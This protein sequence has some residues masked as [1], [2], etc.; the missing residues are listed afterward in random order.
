MITYKGKE[1]KVN[2]P[3][4][5]ELS[6]INT[7]VIL[8]D[9]CWGDFVIDLST[10]DYGNKERLV[11]DY[12]HEENLTI[13]YIDVASMKVDAGGWSGTG[14]LL[15]IDEKDKASEIIKQGMGGVP[16]EVSPTLSLHEAEAEI[17]NANT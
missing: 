5:V 3:Y 7:G 9:Y 10:L 17:I 1:Y 11:V 12:N 13:G 6:P 2:V 8:P 16:F 15:P 4:E 14:Y